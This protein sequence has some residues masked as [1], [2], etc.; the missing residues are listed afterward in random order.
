MGEVPSKAPVPAGFRQDDEE[1]GING[2][3]PPVIEYSADALP[4]T[5]V[6]DMTHKYADDRKTERP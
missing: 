3:N 6:R 4:C 2:G 5:Q 1:K